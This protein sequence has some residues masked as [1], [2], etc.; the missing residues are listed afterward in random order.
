MGGETRRRNKD[1]KL[2]RRGLLT[3]TAGCATAPFFVDTFAF[4]ETQARQKVAVETSEDGYIEISSKALHGPA[5]EPA[6][7]AVS[8]VLDEARL[9]DTETVNGR[10]SLTSDDDR[11]PATVRMEAAVGSGVVS[12]TV[13]VIGGNDDVRAEIRRRVELEAV[14]KENPA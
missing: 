13:V 4:S 5:Q 11:L 2:S 9:I 8:S 10:I 7:L 14:E 12:D 6:S 1:A 3:A